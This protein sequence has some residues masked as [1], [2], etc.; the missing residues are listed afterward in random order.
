MHDKTWGCPQQGGCPTGVINTRSLFP[1]AAQYLGMLWQQQQAAH[2][3]THHLFSYLAWEPPDTYNSFYDYHKP[4]LPQTVSSNKSRCGG[5]R[6]NFPKLIWAQYLADLIWS[7]F[8]LQNTHAY[9]ANRNHSWL[10]GGG[11]APQLFSSCTREKQEGTTL[12]AS[13]LPPNHS[14]LKQRSLA[15]RSQEKPLSGIQAATKPRL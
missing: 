9:S 4:V 10:R 5:G 14:Q 13:L 15:S 2:K 6:G 12:A 7:C 1:S 11:Q 8:S 3:K